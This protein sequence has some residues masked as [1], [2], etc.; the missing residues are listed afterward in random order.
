M[1]I[2]YSYWGFLGDQKLDKNGNNLSTP[3]GN[4]FY[5]W[6]II[7]AF[8]SLGH[9]VI[10]L[11]ENRDEPGYE[12]L[13]ANLFT[14]FAGVKRRR[15]YKRLILDTE[16]FKN[17]V[18]KLDFMFIEWRWKIEGRNYSE[19]ND[20]DGLQP[21]YYRQEELLQ[22]AQT[23]DIPV[24]VFDL[25]YKLTLD[26]VK[27]Y[28][29]K[30]IVE[31]GTKWSRLPKKYGVKAITVGVPYDPLCLD[32]FP[33]LEPKEK[34]VYVGNRY[35]RD[36]CINKYIPDNAIIYGNWNEGGRNSSS[37][38]PNI[39]FMPRITADKMRNVYKHISVTPLLAKVEYCDFG[40]MTA[41]YLEA[42]VYGCI[43]LFIEEFNPFTVEDYVDE[44]A[45]ILTVKDKKEVLEKAEYFM[46]FPK[47]RKKIID[48]LR[49]KAIRTNNNILFA[50]RVIKLWQ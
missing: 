23:F 50:N 43:P 33:V 13:K 24:V 22:I 4:V 45:N 46:S 30:Y 37:E 1:L 35:E 28:N 29:I 20:I 7:E 2:G 9:K 14:A 26:D 31:L 40:F 12:K 11:Q 44:Y 25:D 8:Q 42:I 18:D 17:D 49:V 32:E 27:K 5:S 16:K 36:W 19:D 38:W 39:K 10:M 41:R 48:D 21:D 47:E 6:A 15:M 34:V 3:D